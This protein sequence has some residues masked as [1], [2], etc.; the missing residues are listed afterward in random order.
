MRPGVPMKATTI[1]AMVAIVFAGALV[2]T[3]ALE[4][5]ELHHPVNVEPDYPPL[6]ASRDAGID[7]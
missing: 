1:A 2:L 7:R 3:A 4:G 6:N 5:C